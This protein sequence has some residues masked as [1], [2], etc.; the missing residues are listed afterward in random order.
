MRRMDRAG[1]LE[2]WSGAGRTTSSGN[3]GVGD[4]FIFSIMMIEKCA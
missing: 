1:K 4:I 2:K 3:K